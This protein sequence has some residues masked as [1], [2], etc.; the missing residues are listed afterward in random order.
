MKG[1][2]SSSLRAANRHSTRGGDGVGGSSGDL[3]FSPTAGRDDGRDSVHVG[4]SLS[5]N[6][7]IHV[8]HDSDRDFIP[9]S[10]AD[11]ES[12]RVERDKSLPDRFPYT[13]PLRSPR[14]T[15][16][17][18]GG[19]L[20]VDEGEASGGGGDGGAENVP[21]AP[22]FAPSSP[23]QA[24]SHSLSPGQRD[25]E[26]PGDD[27]ESLTLL[28]SQLQAVQNI[29]RELDSKDAELNAL[30][31]ENKTLRNGT[32][33][34]EAENAAKLVVLE[35]RCKVLDSAHHSSSLK[36]DQATAKATRL[37]TDLDTANRNL[38]R[39]EVRGT[40]LASQVAD[41][42]RALEA[43]QGAEA[44]SAST[45]REARQ[46]LSSAAERIHK[47]END[48][49]HERQA[50]ATAE[51]E[52]AGAATAAAVAVAEED[53][54]SEHWKQ[55][56]EKAEE[57][58]ATLKERI[59]ELEGEANASKQ[60]VERIN[61]ETADL[62]RDLF[63]AKQA[64]DTMATAS[65]EAAEAVASQLRANTEAHRP[66]WLS[67][68][69]DGERGQRQGYS[70]D[71]D[72]RKRDGRK[73][74]ST[75]SHHGHD[76]DHHSDDTH[77]RSPLGLD[78]LSDDSSTGS[79]GI[80]LPMPVLPEGL[81][82]K[83][84]GPLWQLFPVVIESLTEERKRAAAAQDE[85]LKLRG[86]KEANEQTLRAVKKAGR[87]N[88]VRAHDIE[89]QLASLSRKYDDTLGRLDEAQRRAV[90]AESEVNG[91]RK[92]AEQTVKLE[93]ELAH[94]REVSIR[95]DQHAT[96]MTNR[97]QMMEDV[98][99]AAWEQMVLYG[100]P[101]AVDNDQNTASREGLDGTDAGSAVASAVRM[102]A[103]WEQMVEGFN[104]G[105]PQLLMAQARA[106]EAAKKLALSEEDVAT[107][108]RQ[109]QEILA[110]STA[111]MEQAQSVHQQELDQFRR[112]Y[113][114]HVAEIVQASKEVEQAIT[115][116]QRRANS[117]VTQVREAMAQRLE[118]AQQVV[119]QVAADK[120]KAI[121]AYHK[122]RQSQ[123][124]A[125]AA[126]ELLAR[127]AKP[128]MVRVQELA[129]QKRVLQRQVADLE[130]FRTQTE[131]MVHLLI[132][133]PQAYPLP[134][135]PANYDEEAN[136]HRQADNASYP[137]HQGEAQTMF[138]SPSAI[139]VASAIAAKISAIEAAAAAG[140]DDPDQQQ[141]N[142]QLGMP[143]HEAAALFSSSL[144]SNTQD[145]CPSQ[146]HQR[147]DPP[148]LRTV[149]IVVLAAIRLRKCGATCEY[150]GVPSGQGSLL[151]FLP[152]P[153]EGEGSEG[154]DGE[155]GT[156]RSASKKGRSKKDR[157]AD[158]PISLP[159]P[160]ELLKGHAHTWF[161]VLLDRITSSSACAASNGR[162]ALGQGAADGVHDAHSHG[163]ALKSDAG[164]LSALGSGGGRR[165][166]R[167]RRTNRDGGGEDGARSSH[168]GED[169]DAVF[170]LRK[171]LVSLAQQ[172]VE[173]QAEIDRLRRQEAE[174]ASSDT[175]LLAEADGAVERQAQLNAFLEAR[176]ATLEE[177]N[178]HLLEARSSVSANLDAHYQ[179]S[180]A[181]EASERRILEAE[182][183]DLREA[184]RVSREE[185]ETERIRCETMLRA[186]SRR[187]EMFVEHELRGQLQQELDQLQYHRA[188][189]PAGPDAY[190]APASATSATSMVPRAGALALT[191]TSPP[192]VNAGAGA[193]GGIDPATLSLLEE[194]RR[195]RAHLERT[196][197][198]AFGAMVGSVRKA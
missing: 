125:L 111:K 33:T 128:L 2:E 44:E 85:L 57:E 43:A 127:G 77:A 60:R 64:L 66:S 8:A 145:R 154:G 168:G 194:E 103:S 19:L 109:K 7:R 81:V 82:S 139:E 178:R 126:L 112:T 120:T 4:A 147:Q 165:R 31:Q 80:P 136:R 129:V 96:A 68:L 161:A 182:V 5:P 174:R 169:V 21:H 98:M 196:I 61:E 40:A 69:D 195:E 115:E 149:A 137:D 192:V 184:L 197:S 160:A 186:Q 167:K 46:L 55:K 114:E 49:Q 123:E 88:I 102:P 159:P 198:S 12:S 27:G 79:A 148:S 179:R 48:L 105:L 95:L 39:A 99:Q 9:M 92:S 163:A 1:W 188:G 54:V 187:T 191:P 15:W 158:K 151:S 93:A 30:R 193:G 190:R 133:G 177:E 104:K 71:S 94:S 166:G 118:D 89:V 74:R 138:S 175:A 181:H 11:L 142:Q 91:H 52:A 141:Q 106:N 124:S 3:F 42:E 20:H 183:E 67:K 6:G 28:R 107:L 23:P 58:V 38:H 121:E 140:A 132:P 62:R 22:R 122:A 17:R 153:I 97:A 87:E 170:V 14:P 110:D 45:V 134:P 150:L 50:R 29:R 84:L 162:R 75:N 189:P 25:E 101:G 72:G 47:L 73:N 172:I 18:E 144:S 56:A 116:A 13:A 78:D 108:D 143:M 36:V 173:D 155:R 70:D 53:Q 63:E 51:G 59:M 146:R 37:Q 34:R 41:L 176:C 117:E 113:E 90:V 76:D 119:Q 24:D 135:P 10:P 131:G 26:E 164:L 152:L 16:H 171:A 185:T 32:S 65:T 86:A 180:A 100:V 156:E 130:A 157:R 35:E 83:S